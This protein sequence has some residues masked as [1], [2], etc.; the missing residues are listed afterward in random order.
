MLLVIKR[1]GRGR[2]DPKDIVVHTDLRISEPTVE[3][4]VAGLGGGKVET[5]RV[6]SC[7]G[8]CYNQ[9]GGE[10]RLLHDVQKQNK[11]SKS[12]CY[13]VFPQRHTPSHIFSA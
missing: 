12:R 8:R 9:E 4:W 5:G 6:A 13:Q 11:S 3:D 2:E 7:S 10:Y 1:D